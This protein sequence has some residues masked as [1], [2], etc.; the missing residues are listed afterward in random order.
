MRKK[1]T[2]ALTL[3]LALAGSTAGAQV[4]DHLECYKIK[5]SAAKASYLADLH[6]LAVEPGCE[7]TVPAKLLCVDTTKTNVSPAAPVDGDGAEQSRVA[8][9]KVKCPKQAL[10]AV[11]WTDQFGARPLAVK[12]SKYVCAPDLAPDTTGFRYIF[13][14]SQFYTG[15]LGGLAGADAKCQQLADAAS[16]PGSYFAFLGATGIAAG[17]RITGDYELRLTDGVTVVANNKADLLDGSL[18]AAISKTET[19]AAASDAQLRVWTATSADFSYFGQNCND[20]GQVPDWTTTSS[21]TNSGIWTS[22]SSN[23]VAGG[24]VQ[25]CL[26][27]FSL[28]CI[29]Q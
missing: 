10:P 5:D 25:P 9:Y 1:S 28:Y 8:C 20:A 2:A 7:I 26:S 22:T 13:V 17:D 6:G 24:G 15:N 11:Q 18:D 19:G 12:G 21:R 23:W 27:S 16:L 29:Q 14:T 3:C 4:A